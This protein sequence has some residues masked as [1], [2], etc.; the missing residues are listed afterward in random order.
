MTAYPAE[1]QESIV[2]NDLLYTF[3]GFNG[4][5]VYAMQYD[6]SGSICFHMDS[7]LDPSL[8]VGACVCVCVCVFSCGVFLI[9]HFGN[10]RCRRCESNKR[11]GG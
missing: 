11:V 1:V 4:H 3:A 5:Y 10:A 6:D 8:M 7:A 9:P 2:V